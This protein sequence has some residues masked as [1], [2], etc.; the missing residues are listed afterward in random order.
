MNVRSKRAL[1]AVLFSVVVAAAYGVGRVHADGIPTT[2]PLV[3]A[4]TLE[5]GGRPVEGTH[6]VALRLWTAATGGTLACAETSAEVAFTAGRFRIPLDSSCVTA[7]QRNA[8]LWVEP[9]VDDGS[10]GRSKVSA[11]PYAVEA[12]RAAGASG[13]LEM[14][15]ATVEAAA[16]RR[17]VEA[18]GGP[19]SY[20]WTAFTT[21]WAVVPGA[22]T[23]TFTARSTGRYAVRTMVQMSCQSRARIGAVA[24]SPIVE[25]QPSSTVNFPFTTSCSATTQMVELHV[26]LRAGTSY[27]FAI[28]YRAD[29]TRGGITAPPDAEGRITATQLE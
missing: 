11:V 13:P 24:G 18:A 28:E 10:F 19:F 25:W 26:S 2:T 14:R 9:V 15:L 3:Y 8:D 20:T 6:R 21:A 22:P 1:G 5:D 7:V 23:L 16:Q 29:S 12:G 27:T 4:G 17:Q